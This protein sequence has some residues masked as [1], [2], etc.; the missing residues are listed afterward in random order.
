M[1]PIAISLDKLQGE[2]NVSV[3]CVLPCLYFIRDSL[4]NVALKTGNSINTKTKTLGQHMK[5][6]IIDVFE[7]RFSPLMNFD[8]SNREFILAAISHPVYKLKWIN[9]EFDAA[10]A[11]SFLEEEIQIHNTV[12]NN[13]TEN[14]DEVDDDEFLVAF[15][16]ASSSTRRSS[17]ESFGI[18]I[19]NFLEDRNKE[20]SMLKN[21]PKIETVFRKYNTTLSSSAPVE[22]LFSHAL[23]I[24]TPRRNRISHKNFEKV[25][26]LKLNK[27]LYDF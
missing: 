15:S 12:L 27:E 11:K 9:N 5:K 3:G 1:T 2:K 8:S 26:L 7:K 22:R 18:E 13:N 23:I 21:Y 20:L 16:A 17:L 25:L 4:N 19:L 24:F 14:V 6:A 10:L